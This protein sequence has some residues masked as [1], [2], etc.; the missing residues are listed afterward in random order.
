[1]INAAEIFIQTQ[2][3][4]GDLTARSH[5]SVQRLERTIRSSALRI[6]A[7]RL[8]E[9]VSAVE[10][11]APGC[12]GVHSQ[13]TVSANHPLSVHF[14]TKAPLSFVSTM[15]RMCDYMQA[16]F[17]R[18]NNQA[19][20]NDAHGHDFDQSICQLLFQQSQ[21]LAEQSRDIGAATVKLS[22]Q[23]SKDSASMITIAAVTM[24][25]SA[26]NIR[27]RRPLRGSTESRCL[28]F[29]LLC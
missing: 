21:K 23:T 20:G 19:C 11:I 8:F 14:E 25:L 29:L 28:R 15:Q 27:I 12:S 16:F 18:E 17:R 22:E 1:M 2:S 10:K 7:P 26:R 6:E 24:F 5:E 9:W 3:V 4:T 13:N